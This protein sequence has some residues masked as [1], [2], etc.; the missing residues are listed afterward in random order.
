MDSDFEIIS[1]LVTLSSFFTIFNSKLVVLLHIFLQFFHIIVMCDFLASF[2]IK[3]ECQ[4]D[5]EVWLSPEHQLVR[6]E[7]SSDHAN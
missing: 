6:G 4:V 3:S 7:L 2:W 5:G 1:L